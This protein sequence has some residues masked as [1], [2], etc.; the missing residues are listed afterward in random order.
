MNKQKLYDPLLDSTLA[1][2]ILKKKESYHIFDF[3]YMFIKL[4]LLTFFWLTSRLIGFALPISIYLWVFLSQNLCIRMFSFFNEKDSIIPLYVS[5]EIVQVI[6]YIIYWVICL[7]ILIWVCIILPV[8]PVLATEKFFKFCRERKI[9]CINNIFYAF[10]TVMEKPHKRRMPGAHLVYYRHLKKSEKETPFLL[11]GATENYLRF[12]RYGLYS[13]F[14][15]DAEAEDTIV[16]KTE[17]LKFYEAINF[18][19]FKDFNFTA[20]QLDKQYKKLV[21]KYHPDNNPDTDTTEQSQL[22]S[23]YYNILKEMKK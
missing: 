13:N 12:H 23:E 11:S 2:K 7:L 17:Q 15:P 22:V 19:G 6:C 21:L 16:E 9:D 18:Y 8:V 5:N 20:E 10:E 3:I 14:V 1:D 4:I